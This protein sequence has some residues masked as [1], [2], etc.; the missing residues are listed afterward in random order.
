MRRVPQKDLA[1]KN[2]S[3]NETMLRYA[4]KDPCKTDIASYH[5][6]RK[7]S[8]RLSKYEKDEDEIDKGKQE[9]LISQVIRKTSE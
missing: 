2:A 4:R 5:I 1:T 9:A 6:E 3:L 8:G 7:G